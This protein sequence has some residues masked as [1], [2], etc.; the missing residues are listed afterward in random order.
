MNTHFEYDAGVLRVVDGDTVDLCIDLGFD[1]Q[2]SMRVRLYGINAP[3]MSTPEGKLA[4][5][6]MVGQLQAMGMRC[7]VETV[8]DRQEKYG[9]YLA[10]LK[11]RAGNSLNQEMID[12]GHAVPYMIN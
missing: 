6:W 7:T 11:D 9:R 2:I 8:K 3:E 5:L 12:A 4:R 10:I 1:V